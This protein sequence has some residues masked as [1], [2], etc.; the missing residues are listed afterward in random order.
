MYTSV[1]LTLAL[2]AITP[3]VLA[4]TVSGEAPG[5]AAG[6]TGGAAGETV[7][8]TTTDELVSYLE[9]EDALTIVL[10]QEFDFTGTEGTTT[11]TGC[12]PWGT[13]AGCQLAINAND[14]CGDNPAAEVTYDVAGTTAIN[15]G[16]D[17]SIIGVG[18]AGVIKGK[19]LRFVNSVSNVI[20]QNIHITDLNP[21]YVW[22]GDA[23]TLDGSSNIW[24]DHV[25][26][27][28]IGR[29]FIVS[30]YETNTAISITNSEFDGQ[31]SWSASCDGNHYW[32]LFFIGEGDQITFKG[33]YIHHTS[34]RS[35][36]VGGNA[37]F[38]AVNNYW[39]DNSGHAFEG[40]EAYILLEGSTFD[41]VTNP[42]QDFAASLYAP[43]SS[44]SACT[45]ALG[46]AC[47]ANV[48]TD[49]G[50]LE[51]TDSSVLS[52]FSGLTIADA[53]ADASAVPGSAGVGKL[54][55]S[56]SSKKEKTRK[57]SARK[58]HQPRRLW[59]GAEEEDVVAF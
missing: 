15:V 35:P 13:A 32:G 44:D 34:G 55:S 46:R 49:S 16:S 19:G 54:S 10:N 9:S 17:K 45:D 3:A 36:K 1:A 5:F 7:T 23:I 41:N 24:I 14:W 38:H 40:E 58:V 18:D 48:L 2:A 33:N 52:Q 30:G 26:I 53:D 12:A 57:R 31:T 43:S 11:E 29:Q 56:S 50:T 4:Q 27:S 42:A 6:T 20:I 25:K 47:A 51:G 21:E 39:A 28:L 59:A 22:G 8:P 37:L